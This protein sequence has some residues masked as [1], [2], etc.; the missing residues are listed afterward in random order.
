MSNSSPV[1]SSD[2]EFKT[3]SSAKQAGSEALAEFIIGLRMT[4]QTP[5]ANL[6]KGGYLPK[7]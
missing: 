7:G 5:T 6:K 4:V 2:Y 3:M 1:K